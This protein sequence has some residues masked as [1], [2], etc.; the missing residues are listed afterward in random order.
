MATIQL[1]SCLVMVGVTLTLAD[2]PSTTTQTPTTTPRSKPPVPEF[3]FIVLRS[4]ENFIEL[5][6]TV[7]DKTDVTGYEITM[8]S[9]YQTTVTKAISKEESSHTFHDLMS[10]EPFFFCLALKIKG[11][12]RDSDRKCVSANTLVPVTTVIVG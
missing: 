1:I 5:S 11:E 9:N 10:G 8:V 2:V 3:S 12:L 4:G 6:W 7:I